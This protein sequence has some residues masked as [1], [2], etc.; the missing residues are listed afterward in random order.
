VEFEVADA[1]G[2]KKIYDFL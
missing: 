1:V 2:R